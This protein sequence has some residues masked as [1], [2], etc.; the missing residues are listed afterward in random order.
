MMFL[1]GH[2]SHEAMEHPAIARAMADGA[3]HLRDW[4]LWT[5]LKP[6]CSPLALIPSLEEVFFTYAQHGT[7][8]DYWA[9]E[10]INFEAHLERFADVPTVLRCGWYDIFALANGDIYPRL[11]DRRNTPLRLIFGPWT[12]NGCDR[13]FAGNVDFGPAAALDGTCGASFNE[14]RVRWFD[15]WL[16]DEPNGV[17]DEPPVRIFVM[18]GGSGRRRSD[19]RL[20]H[21]GEWRSEQVWPLASAQS[22]PYYLHPGGLL[23][24]RAPG[25]GAC[26]AGFEFDPRHPVPTISGNVASFY[27]H[28][29]VPEGISSAMSSPRSR[30]RSIVLMGASNQKEEAGIVGCRPPYPPLSARSDVL[31]FQTP[32]LERPLEVTGLLSVTLWVSSSAPDTDFTAK[33]VDVYPPGP[34]YPQGYAM[35]LADGILRMRFRGGYAREELMEPGQV[36]QIVIRLSPTS[37][38]FDVG[39]RIR[40]DISSSNFPRFDVNPNTGEPLWQHTH[41]VVARNQVYVNREHPSHITLPIVG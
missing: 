23:D 5:P 40:L 35:N 33:L 16:K 39:H 36:Y 18:G 15:R 13:S 1:H 25:E 24:P 34:D 21:G 31:V 27:E 26:A 14:L 37:N 20:D 29:P 8:D 17:E 38:R 9:Q 12:H 4:V 41:T 30:M 6:G 32:P 3:E 2:D 7:Y 11:A 10:C 22:T 19:G 28:V